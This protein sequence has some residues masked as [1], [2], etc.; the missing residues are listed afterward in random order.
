M[1]ITPAG[2]SAMQFDFFIASGQKSKTNPLTFYAI[3]NPSDSG[4]PAVSGTMVLQDST[5]TYNNAAFNGASV[6]ALSG[7]GGSGANVSLTLGVTDGKG[8]FSGQF[9]QNNAGTILSA[10][11]FPATAPSY[12]YTASGN[13]G[14]YVFQ[15]LGNPSANPVVAPLSFVLY[16]AGQNRGFLLD[17]SSSAVMTGTMNPQG[18]GV[19][20]FAASELTGTFAAATTSSADVSVTPVAA[21]LLLTSPGSGVFNVSATTHPSGTPQTVTG[22][23]ALSSSGTGTIVLPTSPTQN[24]VIYVLDNNGACTGE[25]LLCEIQ[26]FYM[27]N[28]DSTNPNASIMF[29][30]Q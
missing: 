14:R 21:N 27:M 9:D 16:A 1:T 17:Q 7:V 19:G 6:S 20:A 28:V 3:T 30:K 5:Q 4:H 15:M 25:G 12:T 23:Y 24:F 2:G 26:D 10:V 22:T 18:K 8:N 13:S 11:Q 29:A